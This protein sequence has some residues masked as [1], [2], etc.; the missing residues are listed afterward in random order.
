MLFTIMRR[1][2]QFRTEPGPPPWIALPRHVRHNI[3]GISGERY[4]YAQQLVEFGL[5]E[6][7]YPMPHRRRGKIQFPD[8]AA[9]TTGGRAEGQSAESDFQ[10]LP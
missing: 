5:V 8:N 6:I 3:Y 2:E 9:A 4:I 10:P 7:S 1:S